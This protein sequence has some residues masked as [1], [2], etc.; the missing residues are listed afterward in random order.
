MANMEELISKIWAEMTKS[1]G[2]IR[3]SKIDLDYAF[4]QPKRSK[5]APNTANSRLSEETSREITDSKK[6]S[7]D[8][9]TF[10]RYSRNTSIS[11]WNLKLRYNWLTSFA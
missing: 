6:A 1:D 10:P 9:R 4:G 3:M 8:Y 2:E 5:E 11:Y 7:T